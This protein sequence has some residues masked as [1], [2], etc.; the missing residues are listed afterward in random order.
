ML[1]VTGL[2]GV[3]AVAQAQDP[4]LFFVEDG[5]LDG[6]GIDGLGAA[7]AGQSDLDGDGTSDL[8]VGAPD[9][10]AAGSPVGAVLVHPGGGTWSVDGGHWLESDFE[11]SPNGGFGTAVES[12]GDVNGD[13]Y[14]D[15]M[16]G[17]PG[18]F[19]G[20][21]DLG[22]AVLLL[23]G[24][25]APEQRQVVPALGE[26]NGFGSALA[27]AGDVNEDGFA[28][29]IIG[30]PFQAV[31]GV[32]EG[33]VWLALGG[34][35]GVTLVD[36]AVGLGQAGV[37]LGRTVLVPGDVDGDG[38]ADVVAG[39]YA[40]GGTGALFVFDN[41]ESGPVAAGRLVLPGTGTGIFGRALGRIGDAD[42][43]GV[44]DLLVGEASGGAGHLWTWYGTE[45]LG[46]DPERASRVEARGEQPL[47]FAGLGDRNGDGYPDAV[48]STGADVT[49]YT[50]SIDGFSVV[51]DLLADERF[52]VGAVPLGDV[53]GDGVSDLA[54][55]G[56]DWGVQ[57]LDG[58]PD[59]DGD[60]VCA[61]LD[62]DPTSPLLGAGSLRGYRDEDGDGFGNPRAVVV[63]CAPS[64]DPQVVDAAGDCDDQ[65]PDRF[66][67]ADEH[68]GDGVDS[69]CDGREWCY[70]DADG[71]GFTEGD[72]QIES[73]DADCSDPF[74]AAVESEQA[75][76]DDLNPEAYPGADEVCG[77]G[78]DTD[79]DG[80]GSK[81]DDED[82]DGLTTE[83]E[84]LL[85]TFPCEPDSDGDG[86]LDGEDPAPRVPGSQE[87]ARDGRPEPA[88]G[89]AVRS[90]GPAPWAAALAMLL[91]VGRRRS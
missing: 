59:A 45:G 1:S 28:D 52:A 12:V 55:A 82:G 60:G 75:D 46:L 66:P 4:G 83:E 22:Y 80:E 40:G 21:D 2:L 68:V 38:Q 57:V 34:A 62:C 19:D 23:G 7:L 79:C 69:D 74:E 76:C 64:T 37:Q 26:R 9:S 29:V 11:Q 87:P 36:L 6:T 44:A 14:G 88:T 58:C 20:V 16:V 17:A 56:P 65:D 53:T 3:L 73:P 13:G 84:W 61:P 15:A 81:G 41:G 24:V 33:S 63:L 47:T 54:I 39:S 5:R 90:A 49:L 91:A 35:D 85:G 18:G 27:A 48:A 77:D 43:D 32:A 51:G 72:A 67:G 25:G 71:D 10:S 42:R 8:V 70:V 31:A 78:V 50:G 30:A 86:L 89:C